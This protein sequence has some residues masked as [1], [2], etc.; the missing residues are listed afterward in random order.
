MVWKSLAIVLLIAGCA[1]DEKVV[2]PSRATS[3]RHVS[4]AKGHAPAT[5]QTVGKQPLPDGLPDVASV[6]GFSFNQIEYSN[7]PFLRSG[8]STNT[9][10]VSPDRQPEDGVALASSDVGRLLHAFRGPG[11]SLRQ[12]GSF[13][14]QHVFVFVDAKN[15]IIG[16]LEVCFGCLSAQYCPATMTLRNEVELDFAVAAEIFEKYGIPLSPDAN[17][18]QDL[19]RSLHKR[20]PPDKFGIHN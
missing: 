19:E 14:P 13:R 12:A 16:S 17:T 9:V 11:Q 20:H 8:D 6:L 4:E 18:A 3:S 1:E 5:G 7:W 15:R 2:A 10:R